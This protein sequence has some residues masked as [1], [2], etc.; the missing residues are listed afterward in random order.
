[1]HHTRS[2]PIRIKKK[3]KKNE[4]PKDLKPDVPNNID[5]ETFTIEL[6]AK[7]ENISV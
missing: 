3:K 1:M 5:C 2:L 7:I 4:F 6:S